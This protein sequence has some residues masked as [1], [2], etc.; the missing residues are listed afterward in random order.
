M[1]DEDREPVLDECQTGIWMTFDPRRR[2]RFKGVG[3][4]NA[5]GLGP[6]R[7]FSGLQE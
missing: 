1:L 6:E 3:T 5:K 7:R 4:Q 2:P